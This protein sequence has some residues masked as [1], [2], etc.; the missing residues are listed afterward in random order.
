MKLRGIT[1]MMALTMT[2]GLIAPANAL[3]QVIA[4]NDELAAVQTNFAPLFDAQYVRFI[5]IKVKLKGDTKMLKSLKVITD[6]F[7]EVQNSLNKLYVNPASET[8]QV[9]EYAEE[10]LGEFENTLYDLEKQY[11]KKKTITCIKGRL[12][13]KVIAYSPV[14]PVGYKKK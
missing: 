4:G 3:D 12:S 10:E 2:I 5:V 8:T 9:R 14:C 6:D 7:A 13:K 11:A 1:L